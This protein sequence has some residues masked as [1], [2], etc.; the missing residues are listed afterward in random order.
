M[1]VTI[2]PESSFS[3]HFINHKGDEFVYILKGE[4]EFDMEDKSYILR[5]GDSIYLDS[6]MPTA[7]RN[8]SEMPVQAIWIL[9]PP[10]I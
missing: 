8:N 9:S 10:G 1:V 2:E 4:L 7:W 3:G 6:V 5:E